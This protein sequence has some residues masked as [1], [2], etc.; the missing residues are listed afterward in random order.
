MGGGAEKRGGKPKVGAWRG[1]DGKRGGTP[2]VGKGAHTWGG[3]RGLKALRGGGGAT[4]R[5]A[6]PEPSKAGRGA[7]IS[8]N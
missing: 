3:G 4:K 8:A 7:L 6:M 2:E 1:G 5:A